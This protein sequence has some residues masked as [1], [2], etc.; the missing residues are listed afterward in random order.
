MR[1]I[2]V[3]IDGDRLALGTEPTEK[4]AAGEVLLYRREKKGWTL[5]GRIA[6]PALQE[7]PAAEIGYLPHGFGRRIVLDGRDLF[8]GDTWSRATDYGYE[9]I[10]NGVFV[11]TQRDGA[12]E[13]ARHYV[14]AAR[15]A[16]FGT[17][18][19][20]RGDRLFIDSP[21]EFAVF[22]FEFRDGEWHAAGRIPKE[23]ATSGD[24]GMR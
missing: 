11:L 24:A 19:E 14:H 1:V 3:A 18:F 13:L 2:G 9:S 8:V 5:A 4:I 10:H 23:E 6:R 12:W 20:V 22:L 16:A 17:D 7:E 15:R 21:N